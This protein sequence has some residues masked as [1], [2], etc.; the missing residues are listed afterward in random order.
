MIIL[1]M[2]PSDKI[3][4]GAIVMINTLQKLIYSDD[5]LSNNVNLVFYAKKINIGIRVFGH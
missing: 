4:C 3:T 5:T 2:L 1:I